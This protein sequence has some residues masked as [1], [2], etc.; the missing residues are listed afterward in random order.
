MFLPS[1]YSAG[2]QAGGQG[3]VGRQGDGQAG[4]QAGRRAGGSRGG[5]E[6]R[7]V[8]TRL[9]ARAVHERCR[10]GAG[11][12]RQVASSTS[13]RRS[14]PPPLG[15]QPLLLP[16]PVQPTCIQ[17]AHARVQV[18]ARQ[19][20]RRLAPL[21]LRLVHRRQLFP[22]GADLLLVAHRPRV[23]LVQRA[24]W[25]GSGSQPE[26]LVGRARRA[27]AGGRRMA[28]REPGAAAARSLCGHVSLHVGRQLRQALCKGQQQLAA[29]HERHGVR[30][31]CRRAAT[32]G[33]KVRQGCGASPPAP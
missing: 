7:T 16:P 31:H 27:T 6:G 20:L 22:D 33:G 26:R 29:E 10:Q 9:A 4:R 12:P 5:A 14:L 1:L 21:L 17:Q 13:P 15:S 24:A 18:D 25:T 30:Q 23:H 2:R 11:K 19:R 28:C 8:G 3:R 32:G